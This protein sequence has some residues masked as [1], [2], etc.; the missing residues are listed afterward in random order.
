MEKEIPGCLGCGPRGEVGCH[1]LDGAE[2][3]VPE[4]F[5]DRGLGVDDGHRIQIVLEHVARLVERAGYRPLAPNHRPAIQRTP[6]VMGHDSTTRAF[7]DGPPLL[8]VVVVN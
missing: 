4:A 5:D 3:I 2:C 6:D 1:E 8:I 7:F